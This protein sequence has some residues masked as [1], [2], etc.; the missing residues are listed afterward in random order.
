MYKGIKDV[1]KKVMEAEFLDVMFSTNATLLNEEMSKFLI[2]SGVTRVVIS[3]DAAKNE[4]YKIIRSKDELEKVE[5]NVK[6]LAELKKEYKTKL[7]VIRLSF[8]VQKNINEI[9]KFKE[10]WS[11]I[12]DYIDI[13]EQID[14]EPVKEIEKW[15]TENFDLG[16]N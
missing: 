1:V 15:D 9:Q 5:T 11:E 4:T 14:F 16:K 13:Q 12:V 2:E 10:K 3:L 7:P 6:R 8:V